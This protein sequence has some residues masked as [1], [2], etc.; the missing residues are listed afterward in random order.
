MSTPTDQPADNVAYPYQTEPLPESTNL[1][2]PGSDPASAAAVNPDNPPWGLLAAV[3]VVLGSLAL[4]VL[5]QVAG[6]VPYFVWRAANKLPL[7]V[8]GQPDK[9]V[10]LISILSMLPAHLLTLVLAW[11]I[12]TGRGKRAFWKAL[13]W[14]WSPRYG[15]IGDIAAC[16]LITLGLYAIGVALFYVF[17]NQETELV[18]MLNSSQAARYAIVVMAVLTA[19]LVEEVVYRGVLYS[20]LQRRTGRLWGVLGVTLVFALIHVPQYLPN[21]GAISAILVLS[22]TLTF[23]RAYTG[24]LLPCMIIH[25]IFNSLSSVG[26]LLEPYLKTVPSPTEQTTASLLPLL[27][28]TS[29]V[30]QLISHLF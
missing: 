11:L 15:F 26:I 12:V 1:P 7:M 5:L 22:L 21:Y 2:L 23:V 16:V 20:A 25:T 3:G 6:I 14:A 28:S 27:L 13:G 30:V 19:P 18:R 29:P 4:V 17:G 9:N 24:R 10:I 8:G